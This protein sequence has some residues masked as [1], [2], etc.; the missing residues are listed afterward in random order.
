MIDASI[1]MNKAKSL[2]MPE[3]E[4]K[5][6]NFLSGQH[7]SLCSVSSQSIIDQVIVPFCPKPFS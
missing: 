5:L 2:R 6:I 7:G 1:Y 3:S 4:D